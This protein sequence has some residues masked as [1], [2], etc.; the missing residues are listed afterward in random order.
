MYKEPALYLKLFHSK[1]EMGKINT[2][3]NQNNFTVYSIHKVQKDLK[4]LFLD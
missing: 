3:L 2:L 1:E 4:K